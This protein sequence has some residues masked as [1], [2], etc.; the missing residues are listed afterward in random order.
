MIQADFTR[1]HL[2]EK[3]PP[4]WKDC[5]FPLIRKTPRIIHISAE[6]FSLLQVQSR[7]RITKL[8]LEM[9]LKIPKLRFCCSVKDARKTMPLSHVFHCASEDLRDSLWPWK[10]LREEKGADLH[11]LP[12]SPEITNL[13][14]FLIIPPDFQVKQILSDSFRLQFF[15]G[16]WN[17]SRLTPG[18]W[19]ELI[20][21][22]DNAE[23]SAEP[24]AGLNDSG[25]SFPI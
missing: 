18:N 7:Y 14:F 1:F 3:W 16:L 10:S 21:P 9:I 5:T 20:K 17:Y 11:H 2:K 25:E 12:I 23:W 24:G 6:W 13:L 19:N 22:T 8:R 15:S 4:E